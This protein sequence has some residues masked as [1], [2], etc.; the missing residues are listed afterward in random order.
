MLDAELKSLGPLR[1]VERQVALVFGATA[2]LWVMA[3]PLRALTGPTLAGWLGWPKMLGKH[4]EGGIAMIAAFVLLGLRAIGWSG[5]RRLPWDTLLLLG[6]AFAMAEGIVAAGSTALEDR[7]DP[8]LHG[9]RRER[10]A[11][12]RTLA[13]PEQLQDRRGG[14]D[15]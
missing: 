1:G 9:R 7:S 4:Y 12:K 11:M 5:I 6:G 10:K 15:A 14:R 2:L 8:R 13:M 3:D